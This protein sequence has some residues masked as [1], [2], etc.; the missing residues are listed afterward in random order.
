L[1]YNFI[2]P[3]WAAYFPTGVA[4]LA[5]PLALVITHILPLPPTCRPGRSAPSLRHWPLGPEPR[6]EARSI[7]APKGEWSGL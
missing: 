6:V 1:E 7:R 3:G 5:S 2:D 4:P